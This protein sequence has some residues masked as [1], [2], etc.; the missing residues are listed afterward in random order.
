[1]NGSVGSFRRFR[2]ASCTRSPRA[3]SWSLAS[4]CSAL[5]GNPDR[6]FCT[7]GLP[8]RGRALRRRSGGSH[9]LPSGSRGSEGSAVCVLKR[10]RGSESP[11]L[12]RLSFL[13]LPCGA[14][15]KAPASVP[16]LRRPGWA[17][18]PRISLGPVRGCCCPFGISIP[19][20]ARPM[21]KPCNT[22]SA[23]LCSGSVPSRKAPPRS[24]RLSPG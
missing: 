5:S 2:P 12:C 10:Q 18:R 14:F 22:R 15:S 17:K 20:P 3:G 24:L 1:M 11:F 9:G 7:S 6:P 21:P 23:P 4:F 16:G 13:R 19:F 8:F